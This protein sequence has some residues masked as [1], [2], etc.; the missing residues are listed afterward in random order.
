MVVV[1]VVAV[2]AV[3]IAVLVMFPCSGLSFSIIVVVRSI[4]QKRCSFSEEIMCVVSKMVETNLEGIS[5]KGELCLPH[6]LFTHY[7]EDE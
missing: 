5:V 2:A 3:V 7:S 6:N 1:P 4:Q